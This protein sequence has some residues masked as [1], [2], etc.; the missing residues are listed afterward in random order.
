MPCRL[1]KA[2]DNAKENTDG[3]A[4][5]VRPKTEEDAG[6]QQPVEGRSGMYKPLFWVDLEM[7]GSLPAQTTPHIFP[8][9]W[10]TCALLDLNVQAWRLASCL[11]SQLRV[12]PA[13][14]TAAIAFLR[15][16]VPAGLD[17]YHDTIIEIACLVTD[18]NLEETL[19]VLPQCVFGTLVRMPF[20]Q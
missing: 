16:S 20:L 17:P 5:G 18:G 19:E 9:F 4:S 10:E 8:H 2:H 7:T 6:L 3:T 1:E 13:H 11:T 14:L 15:E 12:T